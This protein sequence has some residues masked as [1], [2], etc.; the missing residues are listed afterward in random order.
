MNMISSI[1]WLYEKAYFKKRNYEFKMNIVFQ[2]IYE[3]FLL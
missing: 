1:R 3:I 2:G